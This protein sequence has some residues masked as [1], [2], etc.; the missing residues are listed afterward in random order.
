MAHS[1]AA[2]VE[3]RHAPPVDF[4]APRFREKYVEEPTTGCWLWTGA[5]VCGYG[6]F[7]GGSGKARWCWRAPRF[8]WTLHR[9]P[10]P[11]GLFVLHKC[12]TPA[13]VNPDH[14]FLGT[15]A[16][17]MADKAA[18]GRSRGTFPRTIPDAIIA[19]VRALKAAGLTQRAI[20]RRLGLSEATVSLVVRGL[21]RAD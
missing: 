11:D 12:D 6:N 1:R 5:L 16:D 2:L 17:N 18:K 8:S 9:G 15:N 10:I 20:A 21:V 19:E 4:L 13:C 7:G 3:P 14:L